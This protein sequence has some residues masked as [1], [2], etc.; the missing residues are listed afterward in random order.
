[1][2]KLKKQRHIFFLQ[3]VLSKL[4]SFRQSNI[5]LVRKSTSQLHETAP[6][7]IVASPKL[8]GLP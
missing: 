7:G 5:I 4:L 2:S 8:S 6:K 3:E 1:M